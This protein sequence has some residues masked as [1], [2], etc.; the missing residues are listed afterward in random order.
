MQI[1]PEKNKVYLDVKE[2]KVGGLDI[3]SRPTA[4]EVAKVLA[5]GEGIDWI[6]KGDTLLFKSWGLDII[7]W[8]GK[9][10]YFID[11]STKAICA[12]VKK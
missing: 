10:Y 12:V 1:I 3:S 6:K 5:V 2:P 7:D 8:E 9:K 4:I 11:T